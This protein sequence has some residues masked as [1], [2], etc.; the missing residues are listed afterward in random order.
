MFF[1]CLLSLTIGVPGVFLVNLFESLWL[2]IGLF[3]LMIF[4]WLI[5]FVSLL[6]F[7]VRQMAGKYREIKPRPL[8]SQIW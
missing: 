7:Y 3:V 1:A 5:A 4:L 6:F 2:Q 8:M